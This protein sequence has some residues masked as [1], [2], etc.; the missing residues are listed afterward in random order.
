MVSQPQSYSLR[1]EQA[2]LLQLS[3][4]SDELDSLLE[5]ECDETPAPQG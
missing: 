3:M 4:R 1:V 5:L 2:G